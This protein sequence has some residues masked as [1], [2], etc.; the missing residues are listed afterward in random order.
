MEMRIYA[1]IERNTVVELLA[2]D[3]DLASMFHPDLT[4]VDVT[5][6]PGI[7]YGWLFLDGHAVAPDQM[8]VDQENAG[9]SRSLDRTQPA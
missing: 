7:A 6:V 4:W 9:N 8:V 3:N 5:N 2:T 1:R